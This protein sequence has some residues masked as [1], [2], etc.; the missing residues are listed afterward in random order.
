MGAAPQ[1]KQAITMD[2]E[3]LRLTMREEGIRPDVVDAGARW[4]S[5]S[6]V[7]CQRDAGWVV[8]YAE[9]GME[10]GLRWFPSEGD[11][12]AHL[13]GRLREDTTTKI[14]VRLHT[15]LSEARAWLEN[16]RPPE[17]GSAHWY[18]LNNFRAYVGEIESSPT[19]EGIARAS[20]ALNHHIADQF[21]WTARYCKEISELSRR[22]SQIGKAI[23]RERA[24]R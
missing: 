1:L 22:I 17:Q 4:P 20:H 12:C 11:A 19:P 9:R 24:A 3:S 21:E 13:I 6:Y 7:I 16:E 23:A 5:E 14:D 15:A 2:V 8:Y 18:A 10:Q